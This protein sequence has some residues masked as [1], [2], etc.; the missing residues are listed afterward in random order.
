MQDLHRLKPER[1][2]AVVQSW[3][4]A[5]HAD[6]DGALRE[7]VGRWIAEAWPFQ[8]IAYEGVSGEA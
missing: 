2:D 8:R 1:L 4:R 7:L 5:S 3:V 6:S